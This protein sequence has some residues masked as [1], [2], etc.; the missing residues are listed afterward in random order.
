M[1]RIALPI[2]KESLSLQFEDSHYF[3]VFSVKKQK[4]I[5]DDLVVNPSL[6]PEQLAKWFVEEGITDVIAY[7]ISGKMIENLNKNKIN[8]FVGVE[9]KDPEI[10]VQELVNGILETDGKV[11]EQ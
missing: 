10:L 7:K 8:V 1:M 9:S 4:I 6:D 2:D 11:I 3:N 5:E